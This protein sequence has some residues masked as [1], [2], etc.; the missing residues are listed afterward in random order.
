MACFCT[1]CGSSN[2]Q[3]DAFCVEC[4]QPLKKPLATL[5][6][7][8]AV[9]AMSNKVVTPP[10]QRRSHRKMWLAVAG[11]VVALGVLGGGVA[12][13]THATDAPGAALLSAFQQDALPDDIQEL[14]EALCWV[15][16]PLKEG[17]MDIDTGQPDRLA[18]MDALVAVGL[19]TKVG[20]VKTHNWFAD[21]AVRY[22]PTSQMAAW[23]KGS[24][25]CMAQHIAAS[26][27]QHVSEPQP[28]PAA[29]GTEPERSV[30]AMVV[31]RTTDAAPWAG[32]PEIQNLIPAE[33]RIWQ[34]ADGQLQQVRPLA[35]VEHGGR[36][37]LYNKVELKRLA[38]SVKAAMAGPHSAWSKGKP[39]SLN[40]TWTYEAVA[41]PDELGILLPGEDKRVDRNH[42]RIVFTDTSIEWEGKVYPCHY[43]VDGDAVNVVLEDGALILPI[44][45]EDDDRVAVVL[46]MGGLRVVYRHVS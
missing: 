19:A 28:V 8:S 25:V 38:P 46:G 26:A 44:R 43:L 24:L 10:A 45:R 7:A 39:R 36:W 6:A 17:H 1:H 16:A 20:T 2:S 33:Q 11:V 5:A 3:D 18:R 13:Y 32:R 41:A 34:W 40:G 22:E 9:E 23:R 37:H 35:F 15:D 31:I 42:N 21:S 12:V 30:R 4:G 27:V 14:S 29:E